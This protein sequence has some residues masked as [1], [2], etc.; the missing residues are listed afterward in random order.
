[1]ISGLS[2]TAGRL[3]AAV[4]SLV[5]AAVTDRIVAERSRDDERG[6]GRRSG[7]TRQVFAA[8]M[9][10][11]GPAVV[12]TSRLHGRRIRSQ[13]PPSMAGRLILA[14]HVGAG[15]TA[16]E[17]IFRKVVTY[18]LPLRVRTA[19][20]AASV[21]AFTLSH[22]SRDDVR[23]CRLHALNA[24]AW[25]GAAATSGSVRWGLVSHFLYNYLGFVLVESPAAVADRRASPRELAA[26]DSSDEPP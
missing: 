6:G 18:P 8:L 16:E 4:L 21:A 15:A 2:V 20:G 11:C 26:N 10:A 25:T 3:S 5:V 14:V 9:A 24:T 23:T 12:L 22:L 13:L 17:M 7:P 19:I 1:M